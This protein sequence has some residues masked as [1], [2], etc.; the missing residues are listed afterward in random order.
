[1]TGERYPPRHEMIVAE[2]N[3]MGQF[4]V[5]TTVAFQRMATHLGNGPVTLFEIMFNAAFS[6]AWN[7]ILKQRM[8][9]NDGKTIVF[10]L[11]FPDKTGQERFD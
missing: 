8:V 4:C 11:Y 5:K 9:R 7:R 1:M 10:T 2:G 6:A 3:E